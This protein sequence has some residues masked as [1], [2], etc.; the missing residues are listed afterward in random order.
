[1]AGAL[2]LSAG[3]HASEEEARAAPRQGVMRLQPYQMVFLSFAM[4]WVG[5]ILALMVV[6]GH[7]QPPE[8]PLF[9]SPF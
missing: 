8:Y 2:P 6:H 7:T 1:V 9:Q 4:F 5:V 3:P